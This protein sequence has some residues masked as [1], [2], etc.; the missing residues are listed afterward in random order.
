MSFCYYFSTDYNY[1]NMQIGRYAHLLVIQSTVIPIRFISDNVHISTVNHD[2]SPFLYCTHWAVIWTRFFLGKQQILQ[3]SPLY[4]WTGPSEDENVH[5]LQYSRNNNLKNYFMF[6]YFAK[7]MFLS[8]LFGLQFV[9]NFTICYIILI[10]QQWWFR[11][12]FSPFNVLISAKNTW[13]TQHFR[14]VKHGQMSLKSGREGLKDLFRVNPDGWSA[15]SDFVDM[16][17]VM[18][19]QL[20]CHRN[21]SCRWHIVLTPSVSQS[22]SQS[23]YTFLFSVR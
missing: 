18:R 17:C 16:F 19:I 9:T 12:N 1:V 15:C 14:F 7:I 22:I 20:L 4:S 21:D 6:M 23:L 10:F 11:S 2:Y 8:D 5:F 3:I 13:N